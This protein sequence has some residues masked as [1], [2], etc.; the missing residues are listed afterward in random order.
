MKKAII[1]DR[2]GT[3]IVDRIYL[4][5]PKAIEYL[6]GVF[7]ALRVLR[8][9]G[10]VFCVATNQSGVPRGLVSV[11]NLEK[12]H[13]K[14]R[15]DFSRHGVDFL[16]FHSAPYMTD[17]DHWFRKPNPGML[18]E[19]IKWHNLDPKK[20]W[21]IGDRLSDVQA[22]K[23]AGMRTVLLR[24]SDEYKKVQ[25]SQNETES[26]S[27]TQPDIIADQIHDA[28]PEILKF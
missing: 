6:P 22:G 13:A 2:D 24:T 23:R 28:C 11:E 1:F 14:I 27:D 25:K 10:F 8:D 3:L 9:A 17:T 26:C 7:D 5:D 16:S 19:A 12:I 20:S 21:M 4:N 18:M 15:E